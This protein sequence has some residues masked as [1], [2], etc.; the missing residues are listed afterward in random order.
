MTRRVLVTGPRNYTD[1]E[2]VFAKLDE[3]HAEEPIVRVIHGHCQSGVDSFADEW[4]TSRGVPVDRYP[5]DWDKIS[6]LPRGELQIALNRYKKPYNKLAGFN[7]N[8]E[9][10][11]R[12]CPTHVVGFPYADPNMRSSGTGDMLGRARTAARNGAEIE[13]VV[14]HHPKSP[15]HGV[16]GK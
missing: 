14:H 10:L 4:G 3:M 11:R 13:V 9:M 12:S 6:G 16:A 15:L 5:A 2:F 1:R 8:S 7:R